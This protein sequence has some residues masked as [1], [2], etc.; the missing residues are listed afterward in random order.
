MAIAFEVLKYLR[1][2]DIVMIVG[3]NLKK[4]TTSMGILPYYRLFLWKVLISL[5]FVQ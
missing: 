4:S 5:Y 3:Q 2:K 1:S